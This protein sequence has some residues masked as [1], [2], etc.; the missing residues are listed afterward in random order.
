MEEE[1]SEGFRHLSEA[2]KIAEELKDTLSSWYASW[3][4]G[5][6][7]SM[8]CEFEKGVEFFEK[9]LELGTSSNRLIPM[10][11][12]KIGIVSFNYAWHG[13]NDLAYQIS[14]EALQM[15]QESGD[16]YIKGIASSCHGEACYYKGLLDE[17]EDSLLQALSFC[18]K[19][20]QLGWWT[21]TSGG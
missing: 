21:W 19:A 15:A 11:M 7:L 2:L 16:I 5:M 10:A 18:E 8:N 13:K 14:K 4:L 17:S 3:F 6:N 1:Y 12:A 20:G 9:S